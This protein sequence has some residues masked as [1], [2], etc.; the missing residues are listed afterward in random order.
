MRK[1]RGLFNRQL[2]SK[3]TQLLD[4]PT[5]GKA[6]NPAQLLLAH[7]M[8]EHPL[9]ILEHR[10]YLEWQTVFSRVQVDLAVGN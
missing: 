3:T 10:A 1:E 4:K 7:R 2:N 9:Q 5:K 6:A 8:T